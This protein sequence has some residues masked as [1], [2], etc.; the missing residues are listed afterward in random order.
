MKIPNCRFMVPVSVFPHRQKS[1][2]PPTGRYL[3]INR[4]FVPQAAGELASSQYM[5]VHNS[6]V[7]TIIVPEYVHSLIGLATD[8][9][10]IQDDGRGSIAWLGNVKCY[11]KLSGCVMYIPGKLWNPASPEFQKPYHTKGAAY[12]WANTKESEPYFLVDIPELTREELVL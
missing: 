7:F 6:M 11:Q 1:G 3:H 9:N 10:H 12:W 2:L 5:G 8:L 4:L